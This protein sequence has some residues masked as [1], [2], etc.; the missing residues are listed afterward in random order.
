MDIGLLGVGKQTVK[1]NLKA[2]P[3]YRRSGSIS[4]S[5]L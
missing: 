5:D 1:K 2:V 3:Q 4:M